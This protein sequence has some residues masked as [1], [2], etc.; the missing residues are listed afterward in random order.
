MK[1]IRKAAIDRVEKFNG[2]DDWHVSAASP[3]DLNGDGFEDYVISIKAGFTLRPRK[4]YIIDPSHKS[5]T[6]M[7]KEV[8]NNIQLPVLL[9][10]DNDGLPEITGPTSA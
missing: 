8:G 6:V 5:L 2:N 1:A 3:A 4:L 7:E 9:D 10:L